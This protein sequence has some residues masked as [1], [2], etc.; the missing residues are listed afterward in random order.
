MKH[1]KVQVNVQRNYCY[2]HIIIVNNLQESYLVKFLVK[3]NK[4]NEIKSFVQNIRAIKRE[5]IQ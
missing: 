5:W 2:N 4:F 1:C 3:E